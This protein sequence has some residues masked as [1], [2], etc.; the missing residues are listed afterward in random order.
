MQNCEVC[1]KLNLWQSTPWTE[2]G[3][4]W[5]VCR[6]C[7]HDQLE[8]PPQGLRIPPK[9]L[10]LDIET[11]L[12]K[13]DLFD[14][15]VPGK[16]ISWK[17]IDKRSYIICWAAAWIRDDGK[18]LRVMSDSV[19]QREAKRGSDRRCLQGLFNLMD[20]ADYIV[21]HNAKA[22][23]VKK[24]NTRF[25]HNK[26]GAPAEYKVVDTL[27]LARKYFK[28]N[29]NSLEYW[30]LLLGGTAKD[31]MRMEDWKQICNSGDPASLRK[32]VRYCRG[33]IRNGVH[34]YKEFERWI[35]SSGKRLY[36]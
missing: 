32:M 29:S 4:R 28:E 14:T 27:A 15:Y 11:A 22:F 31:D 30:S 36:R 5:W 33:D 17:A 19:T 7:G 23:D 16:Y 1:T 21:G 6:N 35:E 24:L 20:E 10:Y 9:V 26:M 12:M 34:V 2:D 25:I 3:R 8:V 18:P 13:V